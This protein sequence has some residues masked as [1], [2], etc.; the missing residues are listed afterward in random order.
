[1]GMEKVFTVA[2]LGVLVGFLAAAFPAEAAVKVGDDCSVLGT[3]TMADDHTGILACVFP[4][5][6]ADTKCTV[7]SGVSNCKWNNMGGG[8]SGGAQ[9]SL[10]GAANTIATSSWFGQGAWSYSFP[11][12]ASCQGHNV[13]LGMGS[14]DCPSS[15]HAVALSTLTETVNCNYMD[16]NSNTLCDQRVTTTYSCAKN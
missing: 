2:V 6:S 15:Y 11:V 10:C 5:P 1:M 8:N 14:F 16:G 12:A 7:A 9:G 3:T 13:V 4:S